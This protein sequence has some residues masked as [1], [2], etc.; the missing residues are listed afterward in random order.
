MLPS[1]ILKFEEM[2]CFR[3]W[4]DIC[5]LLSSVFA[6][7]LTVSGKYRLFTAK[8]EQFEVGRTICY[9]R[10]YPK[11]L[12]ILCS[13]YNLSFKWSQRSGIK[14]QIPLVALLATV[15]EV[16]KRRGLG[17]SLVWGTGSRG[18]VRSFSLLF[19]VHSMK[20]SFFSFICSSPFCDAAS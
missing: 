11:E 14:S 18:I 10:K 3:L 9:I 5:Y 7:C 20:W 12:L 13:N 1:S 15:E 4:G 6:I 19:H 17:R 8:V 16:M 2:F